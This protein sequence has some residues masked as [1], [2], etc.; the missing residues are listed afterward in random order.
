[1]LQNKF[2]KR[3]VGNERAE[4]GTNGRVPT[5]ARQCW[6]CRLPATRNCLKTG[7]WVCDTPECDTHVHPHNETVELFNLGRMIVELQKMAYLAG[8]ASVTPKRRG[9]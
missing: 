3:R 4:D 2:Q 1:M 9:E 5:P 6:M 7:S 8:K